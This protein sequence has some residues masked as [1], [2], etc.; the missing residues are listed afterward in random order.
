MVEMSVRIASPAVA[1]ASSERLAAAWFPAPQALVTTTGI[2]QR[3][4]LSDDRGLPKPPNIGDL[5]GQALLDGLQGDAGLESVVGEY[6]HDR[7]LRAVCQVLGV[8]VGGTITRN[9]LLP[10]HGR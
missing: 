10:S 6:P 5:L 7:S 3:V 1:S 8:A 2:S 4:I 9:T